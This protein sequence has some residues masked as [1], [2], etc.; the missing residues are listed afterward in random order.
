MVK[1]EFHAITPQDLLNRVSD[2][3]EQGCRLIQ[4]CCSSEGDGYEIDYSFDRTYTFIDLKMRVEAY[5]K[6][7]SI[8][9]VFPPAFIYENEIE[10][11]FGLK[12]LHKSVDFGGKMYQTAQ[13]TPFANVPKEEN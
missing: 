5:D 6:I 8:S 12:V 10:S 1:K 2:L 3:R 7:P 11:L 4:I 13:P 9:L